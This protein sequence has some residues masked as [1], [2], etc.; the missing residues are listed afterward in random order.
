MLRAM[1]VNIELQWE[2]TTPEQTKRHLAYWRELNTKYQRYAAQC[3]ASK[4]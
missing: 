1:P 3:A 4:G 2:A